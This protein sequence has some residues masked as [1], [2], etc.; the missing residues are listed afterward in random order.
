MEIKYIDKENEENVLKIIKAIETITN[1]SWIGHNGFSTLLGWQKIYDEEGRE[2]TCNPNFIDSYLNICGQDY[3]I[4]KKGWNVYIWKPGVKGNY[5][6][7]MSHLKYNNYEDEF[8][9]II[10]LTP[11]YVEEYWENK[12]RKNETIIS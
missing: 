12:R 11:D 3:N 2:V 9:A 1:G 7:L 8:L 6:K 5:C 10:D 4:T